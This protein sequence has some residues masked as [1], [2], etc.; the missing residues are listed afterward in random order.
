LP[1]PVEKTA[2]ATPPPSGQR[3]KYKRKLSNYLIDKRLQL[4]YVLVV[5]ILSG[6]IAGALGY[7]IFHQSRDATQSLEAGLQE[8]TEKTNN[9]GFEEYVSDDLQSTDQK[10]VIKMICAGLGLIIVLSLY[11]VVMTHKV[12]GPLFKVTLYYDKMADGKLPQVT[13]LRRGDMLQ[14]FFAE[15]NAMHDAVRGRAKADVATMEKS[16]ATLRELRN[17]ADYRGEQSNKLTEQLDLFEQYI[18]ERKKN[19]ADR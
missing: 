3:P 6:A 10:L 1:D 15:F 11:L 9:Q 19:L 16:L 18:A 14:E 5:T 7:M 12:A 13:P 4:R 8:L 2:T 17:N